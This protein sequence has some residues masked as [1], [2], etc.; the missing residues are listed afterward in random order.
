MS[1][2]R[3]FPKN[4]TEFNVLPRLPQTIL[5]D[6]E[7][8]HNNTN[9]LRSNPIFAKP[10]ENYGLEHLVDVSMTELHITPLQHA[11]KLVLNFLI[12]TK[13]GMSI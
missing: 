2:N 13:Y 12:S 6:L 3:T 7:S 11:L 5:N 9:S 4:Q 8:Y 10:N 1:L